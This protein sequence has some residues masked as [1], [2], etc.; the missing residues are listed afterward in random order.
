MKGAFL[1][2]V[3]YISIQRYKL[4]KVDFNGIKIPLSV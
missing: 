3:I 1:K 4:T 2:Q